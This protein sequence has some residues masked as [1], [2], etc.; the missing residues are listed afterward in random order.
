MPIYDKRNKTQSSLKHAQHSEKR[1]GG[2]DGAD[3]ALRL[4]A[5]AKAMEGNAWSSPFL[6]W[7]VTLLDME[8]AL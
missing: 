4:M 5:K 7:H 6:V 3:C 8:Q 1:T 2:C